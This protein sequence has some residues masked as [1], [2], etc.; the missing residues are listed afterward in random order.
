LRASKQGN[1][2]N[3]PQIPNLDATLHGHNRTDQTLVPNILKMLGPNASDLTP[4]MVKNLKLVLDPNCQRL[5][6][7]PKG[8]KGN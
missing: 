2:P 3:S 7:C 4:E 6:P 5:V 8:W 1:R